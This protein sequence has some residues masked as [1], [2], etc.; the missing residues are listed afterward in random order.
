MYFNP[1]L[2]SAVI[3]TGSGFRAAFIRGL[4]IP[5]RGGDK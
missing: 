3:S 1:E 4:M 5:L 2:Y